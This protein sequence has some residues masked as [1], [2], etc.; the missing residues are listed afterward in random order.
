[1]RRTKVNEGPCDSRL[2]MLLTKTIAEFGA[3][4]DFPLANASSPNRLVALK[5]QE[6][7]FVTPADLLSHCDGLESIGELCLKKE[8]V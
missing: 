1:M 7:M 3:A 2:S 6:P 8:L 5:Q 4:L